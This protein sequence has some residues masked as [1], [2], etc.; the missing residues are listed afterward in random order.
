MIN[1]NVDEMSLKWFYNDNIRL[2]E[3]I[4]LKYIIEES[5]NIKESSYDFLI[6]KN[7]IASRANREGFNFLINNKMYRATDWSV[8]YICTSHGISKRYLSRL[9]TLSKERGYTPFVGLANDTINT[10]LNAPDNKKNLKEEK[11]LIRVMND[12]FIRAIRSSN[13]KVKDNYPLLTEIEDS[14]TEYYDV[15]SGKIDYNVLILRMYLK[16]NFKIKKKNINIGLQLKNSETGYY[17]LQLQ[18]LIKIDNI[19]FSSETLLNIRHN[20]KAISDIDVDK[21]IKNLA[22]VYKN[23]V[24]KSI[25]SIF[26]DNILDEIYYSTIAFQLKKYLNKEDYKKI[27]KIAKKHNKFDLSKEILTLCSN[28]DFLRKERIESI[29]VDKILQLKIDVE[30]I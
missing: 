18:L 26:D 10:F 15:S 27:E 16:E 23:K 19:E 9:L 12:N 13:F 17:A 14:I 24:L 1:N 28:Y 4:T 2:L 22:L 7:K 5:K 21:Y 29:I 6:N 3:N 11:Y 20:A 8:H 25:E 30:D